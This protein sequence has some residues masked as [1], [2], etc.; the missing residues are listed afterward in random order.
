MIDLTHFH[1]LVNG[2]QPTYEV[3]LFLSNNNSILEDLLE[4]KSP[5]APIYTMILC[6]HNFI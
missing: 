2:K 4:F 6:L 3:L 1:W 5:G